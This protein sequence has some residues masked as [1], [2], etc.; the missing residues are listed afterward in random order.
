MA[1]IPPSLHCRDLN[2]AI[3]WGDIPCEIPRA[4]HG[5]AKRDVPCAS[6]ASARSG[7]PARMAMW[8]LKQAPAIAPRAVPGQCRRPAA[9]S[10]VVGEKPRGAARARAALCRPVVRG[11]RAGAP[12]HLLERRDASHRASNI[13]RFSSPATASPWRMHCDATRAASAAAAEGVVRSEIAPKLAFVLPGQGAQWIGMARELIAREP[14][15]RAALRAVRQRRATLHRLVDH[16]A[17]GR[18]AG[19]G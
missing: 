15:F 14:A 16:G 5:L 19:L 8:C 18:R 1:S 11:R 6:P 7:S 4:R 2:P 17:A 13:A 9:S 12:R 3:P 10:A